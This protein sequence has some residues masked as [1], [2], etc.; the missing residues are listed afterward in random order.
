MIIES[1]AQNIVQAIQTGQ[2]DGACI[3]HIID[4]IGAL[5]K[6]FAIG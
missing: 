2:N 6:S 4:Y 1:D 5:L 3:G